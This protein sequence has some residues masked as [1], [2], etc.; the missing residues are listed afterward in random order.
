MKSGSVSLLCGLVAGPY[1]RYFH[2]TAPREPL[3]T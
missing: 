1:Q 3:L 2:I